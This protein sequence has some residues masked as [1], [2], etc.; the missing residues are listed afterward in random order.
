MVYCGKQNDVK[1]FLAVSQ[2]LLFP[3]YREGFGLV[4]ME[5]GAMGLPVISSD[6]IGCNNVV[7]KELGKITFA[8]F[9]TMRDYPFLIGLHLCFKMGSSGIGDGGNRVSFQE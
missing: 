2:C 1:P 3:S 6:I 5:A 8:E 9:G 7:T 4:L